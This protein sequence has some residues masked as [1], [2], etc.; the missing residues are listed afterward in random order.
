MDLTTISTRDLTRFHSITLMYHTKNESK[1]KEYTVVLLYPDGA[2]FTYTGPLELAN[3]LDKMTKTTVS[4][5][6]VDKIFRALSRAPSTL[7]REGL[8]PPSENGI[9]MVSPVGTRQF[10]FSTDVPDITAMMLNTALKGLVDLN[11]EKNEVTPQ[12]ITSL[13]TATLRVLHKNQSDQIEH[14]RSTALAMKMLRDPSATWTTED[15]STLLRQVSIYPTAGI[16]L[17]DMYKHSR[18]CF[19]PFVHYKYGHDDVIA[20]SDGISKT[21]VAGHSITGRT[22]NLYYGIRDVRRVDRLMHPMH[23]SKHIVSVSGGPP[24]NAPLSILHRRVEG[25]DLPSG[26]RRFVETFI[27]DVYE[28]V[29]P[30]GLRIRRAVLRSPRE[31]QLS[32]DQTYLEENRT[33]EDWQ[34]EAHGHRYIHS[35][36]IVMEDDDMGY[37]SGD[38]Y[39]EKKEESL[40]DS[41]YTDPY[42]NGTP[43]DTMEE[44]SGP[45]V[46]EDFADADIYEDY[47]STQEVSDAESLPSDDPHFFIPFSPP[48]HGH[49]EM[50]L[51]VYNDERILP[52]TMA[53]QRELQRTLR[54]LHPLPMREGQYIFCHSATVQ[55][56]RISP[57]DWVRG[58]RR[59]M[60]LQEA[61]K[62]NA[63]GLPQAVFS[64]DPYAEDTYTKLVIATG[65]TLYFLTLLNGSVDGTVQR[66][67]VWPGQQFQYMA[68]EDWTNGWEDL[69]LN[70]HGAVERHALWGH[71]DLNDFTFGKRFGT[72]DSDTRFH[73]GWSYHKCAR[74]KWGEREDE[75]AVAVLEIVRFMHRE[76]H[77]QDRDTFDERQMIKIYHPVDAQPIG[78]IYG[79]WTGVTTATREPRMIHT[80]IVT[81]VCCN[82][83]IVVMFQRDGWVGTRDGLVVAVYDVAPL[84]QYYEST[85][86]RRD[87]SIPCLIPITSFYDGTQ[88]APGAPYTSRT[89]ERTLMRSLVLERPILNAFSSVDSEYQF[90]TLYSVAHRDGFYFTNLFAIEHNQV[91]GVR[92]QTSQSDPLHVGLLFVLGDPV[93]FAPHR[94]RNLIQVMGGRK[95]ASHDLEPRI[96]DRVDEGTMQMMGIHVYDIE[97]VCVSS[98]HIMIVETAIV[99]V[100][101]IVS[102]QYA[103]V[104]LN[105]TA[106]LIAFSLKHT[107]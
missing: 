78:I 15:D 56:V 75:A 54:T 100:K 49:H 58:E 30:D 11:V 44:E 98:T 22:A 13:R 4:S 33:P 99:H 39:N 83:Y 79:K 104:H 59:R 77:M 27:I 20:L 86:T 96:R 32:N 80:D 29:P 7:L 106:R 103:K 74:M 90:W 93:D 84:L 62:R 3:V 36:D 63:D 14:L 92:I 55:K 28:K 6:T 70:P 69:V 31:P 23:N 67:Q 72:D 45:P 40:P 46:D 87:R 53:F 60:Q 82:N 61:V 41:P 91:M 101:D 18:F 81:F 26:E 102:G 5:E 19:L 25:V 68:G 73:S 42:A 52:G 64:D 34:N 37:F 65:D 8:M 48:V 94:H 12:T 85:K 10:T 89:D 9:L 43:P 21:K 1:F 105:R 16:W 2:Y 97:T 24:S 95:I 17:D 51:D 66:Y 76:Q 50:A 47:A 71:P 38:D 88:L 57:G 107:F 35:G